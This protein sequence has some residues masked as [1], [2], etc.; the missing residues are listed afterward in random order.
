MP[1]GIAALEQNLG[2]EEGSLIIL[3]IVFEWVAIEKQIPMPEFI[4][5]YYM[6]EEQL[7]DG[8]RLYRLAVD[9]ISRSYAIDYWPGCDTAAKPAVLPGWY[10]RVVQEQIRRLEE[11]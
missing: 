8:R 10:G 2:L 6:T 4:G 7:G 5:R 9:R 11:E 3:P 1:Y